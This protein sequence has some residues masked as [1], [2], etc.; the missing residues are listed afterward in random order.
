ME[1]FGKN[2]YPPVLTDKPYGDKVAQNISKDFRG[3]LI[4]GMARYAL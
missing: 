2:T 3:T 4:W 1:S